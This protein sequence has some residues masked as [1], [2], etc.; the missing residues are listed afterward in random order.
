MQS[1]T[2]EMEALRGTNEALRRSIGELEERYNRDVSDYQ[3]T[4]LSMQVLNYFL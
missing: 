2:F 3:E 4:I 1:L